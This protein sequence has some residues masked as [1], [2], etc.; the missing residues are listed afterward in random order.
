MH[1]LYIVWWVQEKQL[2]PTTVAVALAAGDLALL[3]LELPTGWFADRFGHRVSLLLG[4]FVQTAG[5]L[6]CWL[7]GSALDVFVSSLLVALGDSFRSGA[8]QALLYRTCVA[9]D[10]EDAFQR[11]E[12]RTKAAELCG[13]VVLLLAG[14]AIVSKWGFRVG[15]LAEIALCA[16]GFGVAWL[17]VEPPS[18]VETSAIVND[19]RAPMLSFELTRLIVPAALLHGLTSVAGFLAQTTGA[20]HLGRVVVLTALI[21]LAEAAGAALATRLPA[22]GA[23]AQVIL[24]GVGAVCFGGGVGS[25]AFL[26]LGLLAPAFCLGLAQPLRGAAIQRVTADGVRARAASLASACDMVFTIIALPFAASR[27]NR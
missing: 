26:A 3:A 17:M 23:R 7:G 5:M 15:W 8:D 18:G 1:G 11:I 21:T 2:T 20:N 10:R 19:E 12:A 14:G 6:C 22:M 24:M 25:P 16:L 13:L 4:S 27:L 9:L